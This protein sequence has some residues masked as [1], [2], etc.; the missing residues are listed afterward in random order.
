MIPQDA[1]AAA[2]VA[3]KISR[4]LDDDY[5]G[6]WV[7]P[8]HLRRLVP[9]VSDA[10]VRDMA[11]VIL[12]VLT[13]SGVVIGDLPGDSGVFSPWAGPAVERVMRGWEQLGRDPRLGEIAWLSRPA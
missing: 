5:V 3:E 2:T 7:L 1:A 10:R 12:R 13:D 6:V 8:W 9:D 4:E 11:E